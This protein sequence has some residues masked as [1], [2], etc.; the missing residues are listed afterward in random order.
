[1]KA[2]A[3]TTRQAGENTCV[4]YGGTNEKRTTNQTHLWC[5]A[6][7]YIQNCFLLHKENKQLERK[8]RELQQCKNTEQVSV[9]C[10]TKGSHDKTNEKRVQQNYSVRWA[11]RTSRTNTNNNERKQHNT[12]DYGQTKITQTQQQDLH[13]VRG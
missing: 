6:A 5:Y 8:D 1:M 4:N 13:P 3:I 10:D 12:F 2:N 7:N 11:G 9:W